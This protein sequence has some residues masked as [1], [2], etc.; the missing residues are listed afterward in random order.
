[1]TEKIKF[2]GLD[3]Q[4]VNID[5]EVYVPIQF[6]ID[7]HNLDFNKI[8]IWFNNLGYSE[9]IDK[10]MYF[11]GDVDYLCYYI[12]DFSYFITMISGIEKSLFNAAIEIT[13]LFSKK[14]IEKEYKND[15]LKFISDKF[16]EPQ[17]TDEKS[18]IVFMTSSDILAVIPAKLKAGVDNIKIGLLLR[19]LKIKKN[20]LY[21]NGQSK[22]GYLLVNR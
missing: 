15:V 8:M 7:D 19:Y 13:S 11:I 6:F 10:V 12:E 16:R 1:M 3:I 18:S 5:G 22:W 4:V 21:S 2:A 9:K 20:T 14:Y 17:S